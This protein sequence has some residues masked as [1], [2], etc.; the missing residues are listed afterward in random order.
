MKGHRPKN[1]FVLSKQFRCDAAE[2]LPFLNQQLCCVVV[3]DGPPSLRLPYFDEPLAFLEFEILEGASAHDKLGQEDEEVLF[4]EGLSHGSFALGA[5][6]IVQIGVNF[7]EEGKLGSINC[8]GAGEFLDDP[9]Y[10]FFVIFGHQQYL[11]PSFQQHIHA[12]AVLA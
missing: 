10:D 11:Y 9:V 4:G 8:F 6:D 3:S 1:L 5:S 7:V 12:I 2:L